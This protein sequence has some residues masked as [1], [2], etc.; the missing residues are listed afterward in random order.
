MN[1]LLILYEQHLLDKII[2]YLKQRF[3]ETLAA[4]NVKTL[5]PDQLTQF[6]W[7]GLVDPNEIAQEMT[8]IFPTLIIETPSASGIEPSSRYF[9]KTQLW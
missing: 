6:T 4:V 3:K 9:N 8:E 7:E 2:V 5:V 1:Y